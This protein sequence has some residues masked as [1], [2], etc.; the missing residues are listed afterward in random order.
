MPTM[1]YQIIDEDT[2]MFSINHRVTYAIDHRFLSG[3]RWDTET[4]RIGANLGMSENWN[5]REG[6]AAARAAVMAS[7]DPTDAPVRS[8]L[9]PRIVKHEIRAN[10]SRG[11]W[12]EQPA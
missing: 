3:N 8:D 4:V 10:D 9:R 1:T 11:S 2:N 7:F 5:G 6:R 12:I